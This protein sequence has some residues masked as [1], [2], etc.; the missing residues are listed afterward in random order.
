ML[1]FYKVSYAFASP[2]TQEVEI[3]VELATGA[4]AAVR[5]RRLTIDLFRPVASQYLVNSTIIIK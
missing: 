1:K 2:V 5:A 4:L 3:C